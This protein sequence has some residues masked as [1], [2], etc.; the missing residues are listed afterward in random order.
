[1]VTKSN[2][3]LLGYQLYQFNIVAWMS[4]PDG[5]DRES[6]WNGGLSHQIDM[7]Y[8]WEDFIGS[9]FISLYPAGAWDFLCFG[10]VFI[11]DFY[12]DSCELPY[13]PMHRY[14]YCSHINFLMVN[15]YWCFSGIWGYMDSLVDAIVLE[16]LTDSAFGAEDGIRMFLWNTGIHQQ[17]H[18]APNTR[19]SWSWSS[20]SS[21]PWK[22]CISLNVY[23]LILCVA[24]ARS[25]STFM[26]H[27]VV[28]YFVFF[29]NSTHLL[30]HC[31]H[32]WQC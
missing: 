21:L 22:P 25:F 15:V 24:V 27:C 16:K 10:D 2:K 4:L 9:Y 18:M 31:I 11:Q 7:A 30:W 20:S 17:N 28:L 23:C 8:H 14:P 19:R 5:G 6:L 26:G 12:C 3:I 13:L 32:V 1:M 29:L